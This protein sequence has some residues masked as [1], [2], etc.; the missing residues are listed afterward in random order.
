MQ[1]AASPYRPTSP[2]YQPLANQHR[3]Y[4]Q[5]PIG[6]VPTDGSLAYMTL[7]GKEGQIL[8]HISKYV[9]N[10]AD[11]SSDSCRHYFTAIPASYTISNNVVNGMQWVPVE[12]TQTLPTG[13]Q[14]ASRELV[15]IFNRKPGDDWR[16]QSKAGAK[17]M[18]DLDTDLI[19]ARE[20]DAQNREL[21]EVSDR[22]CSPHPGVHTV[23]CSEGPYGAGAAFGGYNNTGRPYFAAEYQPSSSL[24][25]VLLKLH[26]SHLETCP[27]VPLTPCLVQQRHLQA[28]LM[29]FTPPVMLA[30]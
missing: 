11:Y 17:R 19:N 10:R 4:R 18:Q 30:V 8:Y 1:R 27:I 13:V 20:L 9:F 14:P 23:S 7:A 16:R 29:P 5:T 28:S 21:N 24:I 22:P 3:D 25:P 12:V 26:S 15:A 2:Y 6:Q